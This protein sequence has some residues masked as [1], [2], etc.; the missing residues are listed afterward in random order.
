[1]TTASFD[2]CTEKTSVFV[3]GSE[4]QTEKNDYSHKLLDVG[5]ISNNITADYI[6]GI[7]CTHTIFTL[8]ILNLK[9][10]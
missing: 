1:M 7:Q 8:T 3:F 2:Y 5:G 6:P 10:S 9:F 4:I